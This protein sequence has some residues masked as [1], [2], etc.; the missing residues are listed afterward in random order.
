MRKNF[1][2]LKSTSD[3]IYEKQGLKEGDDSFA[4]YSMEQLMKDM[5]DAISE[6]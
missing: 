3:K 1:K 5:I 6:N 4:I 2:M